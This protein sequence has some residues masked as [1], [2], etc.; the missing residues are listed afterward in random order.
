M[1]LP[2]KKNKSD[3]A[4][5]ILFRELP[6]DAKPIR[7]LPSDTMMDVAYG[8]MYEQKCAICNSPWR[9]RA[10]HVYLENGKRPMAVFHFFIDHFGAKL[11]HSQIS[12]HME[13]H[14][15]FRNVSTSGLKNYEAREE[16][17]AIWKFREQDLVLTA[18]LVE[19][20]DIRAI[21]CSKS[22]ELK[23]KRAALV[24]R[25][26]T[27]ILDVKTKRDDAALMSVN[28]FGILSEIYD[29]IDN[30]EA[31]QKIREK[32]KEVRETMAKQLNG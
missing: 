9:E 6:A 17:I 2:E 16:E 7:T 12:T 19:L 10:E 31:K 28:I 25:L 5:L 21:D 11:N 1:P 14:C 20:D 32:I 26:T 3:D 22:A 4:S 13:H 27:K 15:S 30:L 23:M 8:K 24:E 18:L 29:S